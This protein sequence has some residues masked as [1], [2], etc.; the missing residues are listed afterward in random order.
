M[1]E[2]SLLQ[3]LS[4][5]AGEDADETAQLRALA[6]RARAFVQTRPWVDSIEEQR[7]GVGVGDVVAVFA[8][9]V[10]PREHSAVWVWAVVGD[11][12]SACF[13]PDGADSPKA[14]LRTYCDLADEWIR[15]V[16]QG[17]GIELA[18]PFVL[19]PD[20]QRAELLGTRIELLRRVVLPN[21]P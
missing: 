16:Q 10:I 11:L 15:T 2:L 4:A 5:M 17:L 18:H 12:A 8:F 6:A 19:P 20:A 3:P 7:F 14:A 9:L 21:L 13:A 1:I